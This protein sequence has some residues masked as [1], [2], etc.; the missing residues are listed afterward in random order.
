MRA[1]SDPRARLA[2]L[3]LNPGTVYDA[4]NFAESSFSLANDVL[5]L[6]G[7]EIYID[8][9]RRL[10]L[11]AGTEFREQ[12]CLILSRGAMC[13]D[14]ARKAAGSLPNETRQVR[15]SYLSQKSLAKFEKTELHWLEVTSLQELRRSSPL[16]D[17]PTIRE[18]LVRDACTSAPK[19]RSRS[20]SLIEKFFGV[21]PTHL[22]CVPCN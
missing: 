20:R 19:L 17:L 16:L 4:P 6:C 14:C 18:F 11:S 13:V 15:Y 8:V 10:Y 7:W 22:P 1:L 21:S 12:I 3:L 2:F 5:G 9:L